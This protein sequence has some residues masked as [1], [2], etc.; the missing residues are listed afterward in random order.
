MLY[1]CNHQPY[2]MVTKV[3][4]YCDFTWSLRKFLMWFFKVAWGYI[5]IY[6]RKIEKS[7]HQF[8]HFVIPPHYEIFKIGLKSEI[9]F[10]WT[11]FQISKCTHV[12]DKNLEGQV[13]NPKNIAT[14]EV[15]FSINPCG[16]PCMTNISNFYSNL[17]I[18]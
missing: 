6:G 11:F 8:Q 3:K 16:T 7:F 2:V 1:F 17:G 4:Q 9:G 12:C 18:S 14:V 5:L 10:V 13:C 15:Y